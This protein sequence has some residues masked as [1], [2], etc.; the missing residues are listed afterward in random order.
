[1][2]TVIDIPA[3]V[4][5]PLTQPFTVPEGLTV[6][7]SSKAP[8]R[9]GMF[10]IMNFKD[11]DKRVVWNRD[12]LAEIQAAK[13]MFDQL[14]DKE[15]LRPYRVGTGGKASAEIMEEFDP[16]AEEVIFLP[17]KQLVAGG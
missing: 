15:N 17:G 4:N 12:S 1:M 13:E 7:T 8:P 3:L 5:S 10:R 9:H 14:K 2:S 11:G 16:M 6:T